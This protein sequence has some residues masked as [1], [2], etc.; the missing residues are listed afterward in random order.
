MQYSTHSDKAVKIDESDLIK[1]QEIIDAYL[2]KLNLF[3]IGNPVSGTHAV[4]TEEYMGGLIELGNDGII[5]L[6]VCLKKSSSFLY[7]ENSKITLAYPEDGNLRLVSARIVRVHDETEH[8]H[9]KLN[10][11]FQ[12]R[13][14][15][16]EKILGPLKFAVADIC[17]LEEPSAHQ[18]RQ[19]QRTSVKWDVYFKLINPGAEL[20]NSQ[21]L[22]V[23]QKLFEYD[24]GYL[25]TQTVDVS[26]GGFK[27]LIK[28][29]VPQGTNIECIVEIKMGKYKAVG[30]I[31]SR[32]V[33]C[34]PNRENQELFDM[35][36]QFM[37]LDNSVK[38]AM[39][40][41][42]LTN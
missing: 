1:S 18:R 23:E 29:Q 6:G 38:S 26:A 13:L 39:S 21:K 17:I 8:D 14:K 5:T 41:N 37:D 35:R 9:E 3:E 16:L 10:N 31:A 33:G 28:T 20:S 4:F 7:H 36:V 22:W 24:R 32:I 42:K 25:K 11:L 30:R 40:S 27:S 12:H 2:S 34:S 19:Y 15:N